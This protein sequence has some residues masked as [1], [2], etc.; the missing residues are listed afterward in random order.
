MASFV[1]EGED[2]EGQTKTEG[3]RCLAQSPG[4]DLRRWAPVSGSELR[5]CCRNAVSLN[6]HSALTPSP[7]PPAEPK[8]HLHQLVVL[9]Y[10]DGQLAEAAAVMV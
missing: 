8:K 5:V 9:D 3:R 2:V 1:V 7:H 4:D 6:N 10:S